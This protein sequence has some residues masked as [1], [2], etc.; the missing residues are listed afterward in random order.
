LAYFAGASQR[1]GVDP[2]LFILYAGTRAEARD[3]VESLLLKEIARVAREGLDADE[4][5]RA[6]NQLIA[7]QEMRLQ[8]S[9]SLAVGCSLNELYG[10]GC[11]YDFGTRQRIEAVTP[12][13]IRTAAASILSTN[14][15][16]VSVVIPEKK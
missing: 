7:D 2:G 14:R 8:D 11:G 3:E 6:K 4:I 15:M 10:L 9:M 5:S 13:Q 16:A 12:E 1:V